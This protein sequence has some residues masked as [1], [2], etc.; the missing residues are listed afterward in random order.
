MNGKTTANIKLRKT[1]HFNI[2]RYGQSS[3]QNN[4]N[5]ENPEFNLALKKPPGSREDV[6]CPITSYLITIA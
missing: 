3:L 5:P 4:K 1:L 6:S 2:W